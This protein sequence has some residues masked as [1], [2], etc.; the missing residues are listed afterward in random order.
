MRGQFGAEVGFKRLQPPPEQMWRG[1]R[2]GQVVGEYAINVLD[3]VSAARAE[4]S[5]RTAEPCASE[6]SS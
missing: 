6:Q 4:D 3:D 1:E 5:S 2:S